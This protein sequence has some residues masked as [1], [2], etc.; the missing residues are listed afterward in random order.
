[1]KKELF[2]LFLV[3]YSAISSAQ[4]T[5]PATGNVGINKPVPEYNLDVNGSANTTTL[6][7]NKHAVMAMPE[8]N[9]GRGAIN[10]IWLALRSGRKI[11][12]DEE[13]RNGLN[14]IIVYNN[15]GNGK[16]TINRTTGGVVPNASGYYLEIKSLGEAEPGYG[17][18]YQTVTF[19]AGKTFI[20]VFR[21]KIPVGY[22]LVHASNSPG[23]NGN[24][25]WLTN[26]Q[27]TGKWEDYAY[28]IQCGSEGSFST[29]GHVYIM[30][31]GG[32]APTD[33]SPLI[34]QIASS[35]V[36]DITSLSD[37]AGSN[38]NADM[39]DSLHAKDLIQNQSTVD[40]TANIRINGNGF[41]GGNVGIG[42][43]DTKGYKLAVNGD[44][45]FN[46]IKVKPTAAWPDYV[47]EKDYKLPSLQ[48]VEKY[49]QAHKHLPEVPSGEDILKKGIDVGELNTVL[50]KK[51]EELTLHVIAL[52][53]QVEALKKNTI[54]SLN[55][56]TPHPEH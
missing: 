37:G 19:S 5:F 13:F 31:N 46:R 8:W 50:L 17:G 16:V 34:W 49:I 43:T 27:G 28:V 4:N 42:T 35:A 9:T 45:I 53:K 29:G 33:T 40:Q 1:M 15:R 48:D 22:V 14:G 32:T 38:T 54:N 51:I 2:T 7:I 39:V 21:A 6:L 24:R 10:P 41:L 52:Q 36:F 47:F 44:A 20:H 25:Y 11:H 18:F 3:F 23:L 12:T 30:G 56:P 55:Y 26:Q